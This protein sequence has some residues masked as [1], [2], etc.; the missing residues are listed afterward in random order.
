[1]RQDKT[2]NH[3][4]IKQVL[5]F[6]CLSLA[7]AC[8]LEDGQNLIFQSTPDDCPKNMNR[9][10]IRFV[11]LNGTMDVRFEKT[12][13][14]QVS[15]VS[16]NCH[17]CPFYE[18]FNTVGDQP[19]QIFQDKFGIRDREYKE[20][21]M[22]FIMQFMFS[23]EDGPFYDDI[24]FKEYAM[25]TIEVNPFQKTVKFHIV[26]IMNQTRI[27]VDRDGHNYYNPLYFM[28]ALTV[29]FYAFEI[30]VKSTSFSKIISHLQIE[31]I[32][33]YRKAKQE[34]LKSP[35]IESAPSKRIV[36]VDVFRGMDLCCMIFANY[37]A[38]QYWKA[39][40]HA[41]WDGITLSDFAFPMQVELES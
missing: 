34:S 17:N 25:Y 21:D 37:G 20:V 33:N 13:D 28:I 23:S 3:K 31:N 4:M 27:L 11:S 39:L 32:N 14:E 9:A 16:T 2:N 22:E 38:G 36:S 24:N 5:F 30:C 35:L 6:A 40:V 29:F 19:T 41:T 10:H 26:F 15:M 7:I 12:F 18:I 1:M 8:V